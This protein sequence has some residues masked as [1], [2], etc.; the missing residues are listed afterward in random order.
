MFAPMVEAVKTNTSLNQARARALIVRAPNSLPAGS[1]GIV[2]RLRPGQSLTC[3]RCRPTAD[4]RAYVL[5][6]R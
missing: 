6:L 4:G 3:I 1:T 2:H 5:T